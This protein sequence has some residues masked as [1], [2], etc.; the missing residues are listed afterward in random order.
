MHN[1]IY[2]R[3][4]HAHISLPLREAPAHLLIARALH[5]L[6][7]FGDADGGKDSVGTLTRADTTAGRAVV[8]AAGCCCA[9]ERPHGSLRSCRSAGTLAPPLA[10]NSAAT[11]LAMLASSIFSTPELS[12]HCSR[13]APSPPPPALAAAP[14][15]LPPLGLPK[16][17]G[18]EWNPAPWLGP[19]SAT[20]ALTA[21]PGALTFI[22]RAHLSAL[23]KQQI[24]AVNCFL[25]TKTCT[26]S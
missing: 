2:S 20:P 23:S 12:A 21:W 16:R 10:L 25:T 15:R 5:R 19:G 3:N 17:L 11:T 24:M 1:L 9:N 13:L 7:W 8:S 4:F 22:F 14:A 26:K 6:S 18:R